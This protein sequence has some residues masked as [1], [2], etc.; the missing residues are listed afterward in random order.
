MGSI[1]SEPGVCGADTAGIAWGVESEVAANGASGEA[2][3]GGGRV[4]GGEG[5][6]S[7]SVAVI[8]AAHCD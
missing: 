3:E 1:E 7:G 4:E 8:R 5:A 2:A 6:S